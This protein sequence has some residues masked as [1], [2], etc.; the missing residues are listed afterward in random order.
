MD[1]GTLSGFAVE[2]K[3]IEPPELLSCPESFIVA[4]TNPDGVEVT[5]DLP[6]VHDNSNGS[7][8]LVT[9]PENLTS[10][11]L[12]SHDSSFSFEFFDGGNNSVK[13]T[14]DIQV[15]EE[16][17]VDILYCPEE[18]TVETE[19][20]A[21]VTWPRPRFRGENLTNIEVT[22]SI[23]GTSAMLQI[24]FYPI[25]YT[26]V[27][28]FTGKESTCRFNITVKP[29][30]CP[31]LDSPL[32]GALS[33]RKWE[34][35]DICSMSCKEG[36]D[37]PRL[38]SRQ[39]PPTLYTCSA[40]QGSSR[41]WKPNGNVVDCSE[42]K[43]RRS[44]LPAGLIYYEGD[45]GQLVTQ[46]NI[47]SA[48]TTLIQ[49]STFSDLCNH[50]QCSVTDV[51][52]TCGPLDI[53]SPPPAQRRRRMVSSDAMSTDRLSGASRRNVP[54]ASWA[55]NVTM[56][57]FDIS[58]RY[59]IIEDSIDDVPSRNADDSLVE[60]KEH[61][62]QLVHEIILTG[63]AAGVDADTVERIA[64]LPIDDSSLVLGEVISS[65]DKGYVS[66]TGSP[67]QCVA[68]PPG[69][70]SD[71]AKDVCIPC[72]SGSYQ[73]E[74][75]QSS[76]K[77]C[78]YGQTTS[79]EGAKHINDC[80]DQCSP[81]SFSPSGLVPCISCDLRSYQ[82]EAGQRSCDTCPT[83]QKTYRYGATSIDECYF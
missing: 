53:L 54:R 17:G 67:N 57:S 22:S 61:L 78:P 30:P 3:D 69:F 60:I 49:A 6:S 51:S 80:R 42:V 20:E 68:C 73:D 13:C 83:N 29:L 66:R 19:K 63:T 39:Q 1:N 81:G 43:G 8:K 16:F 76:C 38:S 40:L 56:V 46:Q 21:N 71:G 28:K 18:V 2:Y 35:I 25:E 82:S 70:F 23:N 75:A 34:T 31:L 37:I 10:P 44:Q 72:T 74:S 5:F 4:K 52:V 12:I 58:T 11:Y 79:K 15:K 59:D 64:Q 47:A 36:Y 62:A 33:C 50:K 77:I 45:C 9:T 32:N 65:C 55:S 48:L 24:G 14:F 41:E 26:A 7:L 27:N